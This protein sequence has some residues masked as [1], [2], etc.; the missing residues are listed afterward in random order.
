MGR[1]M[2]LHLPAAVAL[3][4]AQQP[5]GEVLARAWAFERVV[6]QWNLQDRHQRKRRL[7]ALDEEPP[8]PAKY[9]RGRTADRKGAGA[10]GLPEATELRAQ[11]TGAHVQAPA[12]APVS[13]PAPRNLQDCTRSTQPA[14]FAEV[15]SAVPIV[16]NSGRVSRV[17][18]FCCG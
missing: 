11:W 4:K 14:S 5:H 9:I 2:M 13:A 7:S 15:S 3:F 18:C 17:H 8:L 1:L 6:N 12:P 16:L 10:M